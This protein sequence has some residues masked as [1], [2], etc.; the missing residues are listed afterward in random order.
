V[1][2]SAQDLHALPPREFLEHVHSF[3]FWLGSVQGYLAGRPYGHHDELAEPAWTDPERDRLVTILCHYCVGETMAL[4]GAGGLIRAAPNRPTKVFL[5]TQTVDEGRH[6]EVLVHRLAELGVADPERE[7]ERRASAELLRFRNR[8]LAFVASGDWG[9]PLRQ[10]KSLNPRSSRSSTATH[11]TRSREG[12]PSPG[13]AAPPRLREASAGIAQNPAC[14]R[15][16]RTRRNSTRLLAA[17][18]ARPAQRRR[19]AQRLGRDSGGGGRL[20]FA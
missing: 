13:R 3:E 4:E 2:D 16:R 11:M 12:L 8:L 14:W 1:S 7:I 17:E 9:S 15:L 18:H 6:L 10:N 19:R 20:G 5:A